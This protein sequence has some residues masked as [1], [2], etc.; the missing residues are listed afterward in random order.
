MHTREYEELLSAYDALK[1]LPS[2]VQLRIN[3]L[4]N[5]SVEHEIS[6]LER[7]DEWVEYSKIF[8]EE[9]KQLLENRKEKLEGIIANKIGTMS[10]L[11][12][13]ATNNLIQP[14][15]NK[16]TDLQTSYEGV[17]QAINSAELL[18]NEV[19]S[20]LVDS[21]N[22]DVSSLRREITQVQQ[23]IEGSILE[24]ERDLAI[25]NIQTQMA[26]EMRQKEVAENEE[27][28]RAE[29]ELLKQQQEESKKLKRMEE[30]LAEKLEEHIQLTMPPIGQEDFPKSRKNNTFIVDQH[31]KK[32]DL[33]AID[34]STLRWELQYAEDE[35]SAW[36]KKNKLTIDENDKVIH[37]AQKELKDLFDAS[38]SISGEKSQD[39]QQ[40][41]DRA[42]QKIASY[43][44][45]S[46][47]CLL[48]ANQYHETIKVC[49]D[50]VAALDAKVRAPNDGIG[51]ELFIPP[52]V[53]SPSPLS[54]NQTL[55]P[56]QS[57]DLR[58]KQ[59]A[60]ALDQ[61]LRRDAG[62]NK[63]TKITAVQKLAYITALKTW[64]KSHSPNN[65]ELEIAFANY[66]LTVPDHPLKDT[67]RWLGRYTNK[68][69]S[70]AIVQG[71]LKNDL[72]KGRET[73]LVFEKQYHGFFRNRRS[74][75]RAY[76]NPDQAYNKMQTNKSR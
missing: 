67:G 46:K 6:R 14:F 28:A 42:Q 4:K 13:D 29:A 74:S 20:S 32:E 9:S 44:S 52:P 38:Q 54:I 66:L 61:E 24:I 75:N 21:F 22:Q 12:M 49:K 34:L 43:Q 16:I 60:E 53:V 63:G 68:T 70:M 39:Y 18:G 1:A 11:D 8:G 56:S 48:I 27:K 7:T 62:I 55:E 37:L 64:Q 69:T 5:T 30:A 58:L 45:D 31:L 2:A 76:E 25:N 51:V 41:L 47:E 50:R 59:Q 65:K 36:L 3:L 15:E 33:D 57:A 23:K 10:L 73:E 40:N 35:F 19:D 26:N 17:V 72:E 71:L